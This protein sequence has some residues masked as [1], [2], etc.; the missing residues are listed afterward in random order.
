MVDEKVAEQNQFQ[1]FLQ[2]KNNKTNVAMQGAQK[3][4]NL[5][6]VLDDFGEEFVEEYNTML[7]D[8][9]DEVKM[10][11]KG[12]MGGAE[13]RQ[14]LDYLIER[15]HQ[16][17]NT[18]GENVATQ[19]G[20]LGYLPSPSEEMVGSREEIKGDYVSQAEWQNFLK[21]QNAKMDHLFAQLKEE[22]EEALKRLMNQLSMTS[23][24][25]AAQMPPPGVQQKPDYSEIIEEPTKRGDS[26]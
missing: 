2:H 7:L 26:S 15:S 18:E 9:S 10:A 20:A 23:A 24:V 16:R 4:I 6:R 13:V 25:K 21:E 22:Q 8:A 14:Y 19:G 17:K 11:L 1:A 5:Y 12:L 3:L